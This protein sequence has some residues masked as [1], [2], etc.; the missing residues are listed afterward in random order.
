[1]SNP[2][3]GQNSLNEVKGYALLVIKTCSDGKPNPTLKPNPMHGEGKTGDANTR[4]RLTFVVQGFKG[5]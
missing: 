5:K 2:P 1:M 4:K 3:N